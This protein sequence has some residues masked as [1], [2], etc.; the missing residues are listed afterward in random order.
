MIFLFLFMTILHGSILLNRS[1]VCKMTYS[2]PSASIS[3]G[4]AEVF[5]MQFVYFVPQKQ[6]ISE[7]PFFL[8][9]FRA[10]N[11]INSRIWK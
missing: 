1:F 11:R 4:I 8:V 3:F 7:K 2:L 9:T 5:S 10:F 6:R